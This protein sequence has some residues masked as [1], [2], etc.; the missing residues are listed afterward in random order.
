MRNE[1]GCGHASRACY[2]GV[3]V[4]GELLWCLCFS[5]RCSMITSAIGL[6]GLV[7]RGLEVV[8]DRAV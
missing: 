2:V 4:S 6:E 8:L 3:N 5:R 7:G 1:G